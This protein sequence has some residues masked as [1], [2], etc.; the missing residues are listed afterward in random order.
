MSDEFSKCQDQ[1]CG[2]GG[3]KCQCCNVYIGKERRILN[4]LARISI[5]RNT[6]NIIKEELNED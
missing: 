5:K 3:K 6:E 4:K 1:R 2:I